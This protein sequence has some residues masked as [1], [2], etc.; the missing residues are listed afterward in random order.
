MFGV[1]NVAFF[2]HALLLACGLWWCIRILG[3]FGRDLA[4][5]RGEADATEKGVIIAF[6][7]ITAGV[8]FLIIRFMAGLLKAILPYF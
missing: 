5:V 6:W 7:L 8:L 1:L 2:L 4:R 3:R